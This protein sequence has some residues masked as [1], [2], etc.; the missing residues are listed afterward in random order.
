MAIDKKISK[1]CFQIS[2]ELEDGETKFNSA[3]KKSAK[4]KS[5][6]RMR[7]NKLLHHHQEQLINCATL[8]LKQ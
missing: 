2:R 3:L 1:K 8:T 6:H 7:I 5:T 4:Q